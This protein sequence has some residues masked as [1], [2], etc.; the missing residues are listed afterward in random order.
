MEILLLRSFIS[1]SRILKEY[2]YKVN[3]SEME[4]RFLAVPSAV[5]LSALF[6]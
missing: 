4:R 2:S 1:R 6:Q 3:E 5:F